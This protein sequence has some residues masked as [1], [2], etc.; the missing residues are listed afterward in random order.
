M[1]VNPARS[2]RAAD[3]HRRSAV[4]DGRR[5]RRSAASQPGRSRLRRWPRSPA[6][7]LAL[8]GEPGTAI[9]I[10]WLFKHT[11]L[12]LDQTGKV[13]LGS[14]VVLYMAAAWY[15]TELPEERSGRSHGSSSCSCSPW[16][17]TSV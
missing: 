4:D 11:V 16:A 9:E 3:R 7:A 5:I 15:A 2:T 17:A 10:P 1:T 14:P 8:F 13:F 6:L 12:L